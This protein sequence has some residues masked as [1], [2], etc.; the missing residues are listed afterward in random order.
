MAAPQQWYGTAG[1][2]VNGKGFC[3]MWS[4]WRVARD[5][6]DVDETEANVVIALDRDPARITP[7][8]LPRRV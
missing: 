8:A 3:R 7:A 2:G 6:V 4:D 5:R 1:I